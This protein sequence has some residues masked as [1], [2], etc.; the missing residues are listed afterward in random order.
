MPTYDYKCEKCNKVFEVFQSMKDK[1][2]IAC[3]Y[4]D[5]KV[6]RVFHPAGIVFKGSGFHVTDYK[7]K[8]S[9]NVITGTSQEK[10][11]SDSSKDKK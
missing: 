3:K 4:C 7:S 8:G 5:G 1:P 2:L 9:S 10:S 6:S 11:K